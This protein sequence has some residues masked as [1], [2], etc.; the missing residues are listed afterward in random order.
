MEFLMTKLKA[1][2][3]CIFCDNPIDRSGHCEHCRG[4]TSSCFGCGEDID[5]DEPKNLDRSGNTYHWR[6]YRTSPITTCGYCHTCFGTSESTMV[7]GDLHYHGRCFYR[8]FFCRWC[9]SE[10]LDEQSREKGADNTNYHSA[11]LKEKVVIDRYIT[12][13]NDW[14]GRLNLMFPKCRERMLFDGGGSGEPPIVTGIYKQM[15]ATNWKLNSIIFN[16]TPDE[17]KT[18]VGS[19]PSSSTKE[20]VLRANYPGEIPP[21]VAKIVNQ[22]DATRWTLGM[23]IFDVTPDE[24]ENTP[25]AP[26]SPTTRRQR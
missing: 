19:E 22:I 24:K 23:I 5:S 8:I 7:H 18:V 16:T 2:D 25:P 17:I 14:G 13:I 26:P 6:C 3:Y 12:H 4:A 15:N 10:I 9:N 1:S 11:C 20:I 21:E